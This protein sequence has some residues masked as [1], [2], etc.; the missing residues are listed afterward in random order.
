[1]EDP[2]CRAAQR[3]HCG[4][5]S[6]RRRAVERFG[7]SPGGQVWAL[8]LPS[9]VKTITK[10]QGDW[11]ASQGVTAIVASKLPPQALRQLAAAARQAKLI[12]IAPRT[13]VPKTSCRSTAGTLRSC[14]ASAGT[15]AA[16]VKLARRSLV[17]YVIVRV[18]TLQQVK[19]L[20]GS[21]TARSRIVAILPLDRATA[22]R[23]AVTFASADAA[24]DL[25]IS[26][27]PARS[28]RLGGYL[29]LLPRV[30]TPNQADSQ[31]PT[32]PQGMAFSRRTKTTVSLVWK[33][34]R[35]NI[36]VAGYRLF[37]NGVSVA[38]K[39][40]PGY[41]Y[42]RLRCGTRYTFALVAYDAAGNTSLRA[43]ATGATSTLACSGASPPPPNPPSPPPVAGATV[44]PGQS[45]QAAYNA[46][47]ANSSLN[48][49]AGNHG[50]QGLSGSKKVTFVGA[51]GAV[52]RELV[53]NASNVTLD[54]VDIDGGGA[55]ATILRNSGD[56]NHYKN[57]EIR[58]V[59]DVQMITNTGDAAVYD[60]VFAH[61]AVMTTAGENAGVHMECM[62]SSGPGLVVRNSVFRDCAVMDILITRGDWYG[63]PNYCCVVLENNIFHPS[64][65]INNG[66]VHYYTV[67]THE[68]AD[69]IDRYQIRNNRFDLPF[70]LGNNPVVNSTF[71]GNTGRTER[72]W[73]P[74]C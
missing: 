20:R 50:E 44:Q 48:V 14:A 2:G 61:G 26:A 27:S 71:C 74:K 46:A 49:A 9:S 69:K 16:A 25:G 72:W 34:S 59:T 15:A 23:A 7:R 6:R 40:A 52:V 45:W 21:R 18:R 4:G 65:R 51:S 73:A 10:A 57:L 56:N 31:S 37:R 66:G 41:T 36:H 17:D 24:L 13:G 58:N 29:S 47:A 19:M 54:N 30:R 55:K 64:E 39:T 12:V 32:V 38:T 33:A 70:S 68:N 1:M 60:H 3:G 67:V 42:K 11:L 43:E 22:W 62:W 5:D 53:V 35:D 8:A 28:S 63:Q